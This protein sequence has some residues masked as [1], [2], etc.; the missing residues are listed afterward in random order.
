M[1]VLL[2]LCATAVTAAGISLKDDMDRPIR[3]QAPAQRI[4]TLAPFLTELVFDAGAGSRVVG[5][6]AYSDWP[7]QAKSLPQV[8]N[9]MNFSVEQIAAL[10]PD[11][12]LIW[13]DSMR[14]E[15]IERIE[16]FGATVFVATA[17]TLDDVPRLLR[18]LGAL[19][20]HD[21]SEV[22]AGYERKLEGLRRGQAGR[23]RV[24]VFLEIWNKPLTTISGRHFMNE[25][26]E[27]CG[28]DN[29]FKDLAGVAPMVSWEE[30]YQRD[31]A[32]IVGIGSGMTEPEFRANWRIRDTLSAVKG[33]RLVYVEPDR[34]Q[35]PTARTPDGIAQL[36]AALDRVR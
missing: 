35:R 29:V 8:G 32:V 19:T 30:I 1:G 18:I 27:I 13:R 31:P 36:C 34:L 16:A 5:V 7:P 24:T 23:P 33:N 28:A 10:R 11:L 9:A 20:A 3:M 21:A 4:V 15:D 6:S 14:R 2:A 25:A 12:V 22:A 26:L 17:R